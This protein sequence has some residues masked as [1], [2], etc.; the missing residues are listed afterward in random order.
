[1][2]VVVVCFG[3]NEKRRAVRKSKVHRVKGR[4]VDVEHAQ[5]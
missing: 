5:S 2:F 4:G 3:E 1:M